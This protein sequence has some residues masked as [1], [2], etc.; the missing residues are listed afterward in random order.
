M[1]CSL[2]IELQKVI[3]SLTHFIK[4]KFSERK[5]FS[6]VFLLASRVLSVER[7]GEKFRRAEKILKISLGLLAK[8]KVMKA[9]RSKIWSCVHM[10]IGIHEFTARFLLFLSSFVGRPSNEEIFMMR[11]QLVFVMRKF[12][13][14]VLLNQRSFKPQL[15][16]EVIDRCPDENF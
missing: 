5:L 4:C 8:E 1:A 9:T 12:T 13:E 15:S 11:N 6:S 2:L 3:N 7:D 10:L 14:L 16:Y